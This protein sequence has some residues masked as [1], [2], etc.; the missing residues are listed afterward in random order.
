MGYFE[1]IGESA[2]KENPDG[3]GWIYYPN[4]IFSTGRL[5]TSEDKRKKLAKFH[6]RS[7]STLMFLGALYGF[8]LDFSDFTMFDA[9]FPIALL[10]SFFTWQYLLVS[11]LPKSDIKLKY[12]E[13]SKT[14][15]KGLPQWYSTFMFIV[16]GLCILLGTI[17]PLTLDKSFSETYELSL[18]AVGTGLVGVIAALLVRKYK[19]G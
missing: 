16:S 17:I 8:Q 18:I 1:A 5:V 11:K 14:A 15:F 7:T 9:I 6:R 13:A 12:K 3:E 2:F 10:L 4:G 19:S